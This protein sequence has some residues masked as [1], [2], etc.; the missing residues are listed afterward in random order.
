MRL[1][2]SP[3]GGEVNMENEM[4]LAK[5]PA[6][7]AVG[8]NAPVPAAGENVS[9][10]GVLTPTPGTPAPGATL[11]P[12]TAAS[13]PTPLAPM[14]GR[15]SQTPAQQHADS[16]AGLD[17]RPEVAFKLENVGKSGLGLYHVGV[18]IDGTPKHTKMKHLKPGE[19][20]TVH[21]SLEAL[22]IKEEPTV[23]P[24]VV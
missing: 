13:A 20:T 11:A 2:D 10:T 3:G 6:P 8:T 22:N 21:S 14:P 16:H 17:N 18:N 19:S 24:P 15:A 5:G 23:T 4:P 1:G 7:T 9:L 12:T